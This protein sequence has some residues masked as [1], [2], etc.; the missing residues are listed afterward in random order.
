MLPAGVSQLPPGAFMGGSHDEVEKGGN[1]DKSQ[2]AENSEEKR[3]DGVH[4]GTSFQ[5]SLRTFSEKLETMIS[6]RFPGAVP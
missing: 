6:V 3:D 2:N 5:K 1:H 4:G